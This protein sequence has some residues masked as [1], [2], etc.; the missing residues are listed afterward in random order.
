VSGVGWGIAVL[1]ALIAFDGQGHGLL[2][3]V[4]MI[5]GSIMGV[6]WHTRSDDPE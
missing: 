4:L 1:G 2:G 6:Y 5:V 3:L